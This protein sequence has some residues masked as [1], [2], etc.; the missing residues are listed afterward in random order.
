MLAATLP[1][2]A[3]GSGP[4]GSNGTPTPTP[5][6]TPGPVAG[7]YLLQI[8]PAAGCPTP[9]A[10]FSFP[11][12]AAVGGSTPKPGT[13]VVLTG[14]PGALEAEFLSENRTLRGGIGATAD[15]VVANE[16]FRLWI[17]VIGNA[18]VTRAADGRGEVTSGTLMG[19]LAFGFPSGEEGE[20]GFCT[21]GNHTFT[22]VAR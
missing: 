5:N 9:S 20:L 1:H 21:S 22:L 13:Q 12:D 3:C 16:S 18:S 10:T 8:R 15:G 17:R 7:R 4:G 6:T 11:M 14:A 19:T 2:A